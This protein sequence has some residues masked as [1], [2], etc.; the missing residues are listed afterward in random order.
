[1]SNAFKE[2]EEK[3]NAAATQLEDTALAEA[4]TLP[5]GPAVT[6]TPSEEKKETA[7]PANPSEEKKET[8]APANPNEEK[9]E[10]AAAPASPLDEKKD[11]AAPANPPEEKKGTEGAAEAANP[12]AK[13]KTDE[14]KDFVIS[15]KYTRSA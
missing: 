7:A 11:T 1:M 4:E 8:A 3:Q 6:A 9:K 10:D 5:M 2:F 15:R 12:D 13:Q 14:N